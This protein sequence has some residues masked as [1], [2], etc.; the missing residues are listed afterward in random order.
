LPSSAGIAGIMAWAIEISV[1]E[2]FTDTL[3]RPC[4]ISSHTMTT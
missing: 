3:L 4:H 1:N 2:T